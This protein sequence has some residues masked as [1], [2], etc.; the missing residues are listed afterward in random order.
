M[1]ENSLPVEDLV[2]IGNYSF[3]PWL[4]GGAYREIVNE[5]YAGHL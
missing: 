3:Y 2:M 1:M 4:F 5:K